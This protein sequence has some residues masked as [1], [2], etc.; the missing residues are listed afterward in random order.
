MCES[1]LL[2]N[3]LLIDFDFSALQKGEEVRGC[4]MGS[5]RRRRNT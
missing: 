5:G 3:R 4:R 1:T 2:P